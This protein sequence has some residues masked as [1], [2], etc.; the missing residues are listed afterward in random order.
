MMPASPTADLILIQAR[1]ALGCLEFGLDHP[2]RGGHLGQGQQ[3]RV[4]GSV[5][6]VV[7]RLRPVQI[8]AKQQPAGA[9]GQPIAA[10]PDA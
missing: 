9:A 6:Q 8:A 2:P 4:S 5:G 10:F 3:Q 7:A 1:F